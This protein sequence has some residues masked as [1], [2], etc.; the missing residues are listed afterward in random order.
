MGVKVP[1]WVCVCGCVAIV[2]AMYFSHSTSFV[3]LDMNRALLI[4]G[5]RLSKSQMNT[6]QQ[7]EIMHRYAVALPKVILDYGRAHHVM[8]IGAS[9]LSSTNALDVT[10][11]IAT[12]ALEKLTHEN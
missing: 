11:E 8:V 6:A 7:K 3:I 1:L 2:L 5:A 10:D 4:P 12:L 9:V